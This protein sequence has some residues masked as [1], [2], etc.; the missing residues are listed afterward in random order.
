MQ[1]LE[2]ADRRDIDVLFKLSRSDRSA[3]LALLSASERAAILQIAKGSK[4]RLGMSHAVASSLKVLSPPLR[5]LVKLAILDAR[6]AERFTPM[7]IETLKVLL[8]TASPNSVQ[9]P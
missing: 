6:G 1:Y 2:E 8:T 5:K 3:V 4:K 9:R 7:T